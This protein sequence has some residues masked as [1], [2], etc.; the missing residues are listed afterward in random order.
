MPIDYDSAKRLIETTFAQTEVDLLQGAVPQVSQRVRD[1]CEVVFA[2]STQAYREVLLGCLIARMQDKN[3]NIRQPYV[4]L[5]TNAFSGRSLDERVINPFLHDKRIPSS[6]G[7]YLSVFRRSVRFESRTRAGLRDEAGYDAF[8]NLITFIESVRQDADLRSILRYLL[9]KFAQLREAAAVPLTRLQRI[10]LEQYDALV[11]GLLTTPSGGRFPVLLV[12]ATFTAIKEFFGLNWSV[13][14]QG[15]NVSDTAAG[16]GGD[17]T[18]RSGDQMLM[19][20]EVTERPVEKSRIIAT[21]NTKIAPAEIEDYLFF[22]KLSGVTP[23][24]KQQA[25]QYFSQGHEVNFLEIKDWILISLATMGKKGRATFNKVLLN[26][27]D[28]ADTPKTLKVAWN[29]QITRILS[30]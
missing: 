10:S 19:V 13:T 11:S 25:H 21:F 1:A 8:L 6:R 28:A 30:V 7:P 22:T 12:V 23:E 18:I 9:C 26:L 27:L 24:A 3:I 29:E 16:A 5:G 4:K 17:I 2:S 15:I 20:A 14:W